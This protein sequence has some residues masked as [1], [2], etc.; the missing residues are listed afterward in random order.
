M[1]QLKKDLKNNKIAGS[2]I[3][4]EKFGVSFRCLDHIQLELVNH[5]SLN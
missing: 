1:Q 4:Q 5:V 3:L 2:D